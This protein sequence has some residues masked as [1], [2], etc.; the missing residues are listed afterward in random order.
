MKHFTQK[1]P[2]DRTKL[3]KHINTKFFYAIYFNVKISQ[4]TVVKITL[5][6]MG[7]SGFTELVSA[8]KRIHE[9]ITIHHPPHTPLAC[10]W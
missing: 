3:R 6:R 2:K 9:H 7:C 5:E 1:N 10:L 4:S 8:M